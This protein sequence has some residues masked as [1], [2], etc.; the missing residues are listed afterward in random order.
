[1]AL[2]NTALFFVCGLP[3]CIDYFNM[4]RVYTGRLSSVLEKK[5]N[6]WLN[7]Y[8]RAPGILYTAYLLWIHYL[9]DYPGFNQ[10]HGI[11]AVLVFIWNAQ[12]FAREVCVSYGRMER[13]VEHELEIEKKRPI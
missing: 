8:L 7:I 12:Y 10:W 5:Y 4:Y 9:F 13:T 1:V 6:S 3:G 2:G 11:L